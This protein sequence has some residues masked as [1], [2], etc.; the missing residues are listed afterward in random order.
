MSEMLPIDEARAEHFAST[1]LPPQYAIDMDCLRAIFDAGF[2][3]GCPH[4]GAIVGTN[5][6]SICDRCGKEWP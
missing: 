3:A 2:R 5:G 1:R 6:N 4:E